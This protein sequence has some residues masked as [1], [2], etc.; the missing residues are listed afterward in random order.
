MSRLTTKQRRARKRGRRPA[1]CHVFYGPARLVI[2]GRE[3]AVLQSFKVVHTPAPVDWGKRQSWAAG[4]N[5]DGTFTVVEE[6]QP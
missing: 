4:L 3:I 2:D 1:N 6:G 5:V